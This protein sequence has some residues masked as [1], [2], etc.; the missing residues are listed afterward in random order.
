[1]SSLRLMYR[2]CF[3]VK[4]VEFLR[5]KISRVV[6]FGGCHAADRRSVF[7]QFYK[8]H[9]VRFKTRR[10]CIR[11]EVGII[12]SGLGLGF[13]AAALPGTQTRIDNKHSKRQP[14]QQSTVF[15]DDQRG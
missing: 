5:K 13:G 3:G 8:L 15:F 10:A 6:R 7:S 11:A 12:E 14:W 4:S 2:K 9:G 1:M